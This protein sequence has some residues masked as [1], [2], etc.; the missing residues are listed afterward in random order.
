VLVPGSTGT[1]EYWFYLRAPLLTAS[2]VTV[3]TLHRM[4]FVGSLGGMQNNKLNFNQCNT[5]L[6][7]GH[8]KSLPTEGR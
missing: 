3:L 4:S 8:E 1:R 5:H 2:R 7:N 6:N